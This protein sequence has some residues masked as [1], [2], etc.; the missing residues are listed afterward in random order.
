LFLGVATGRGNAGAIVGVGSNMKEHA[1]FWEG[2]GVVLEAVSGDGEL[3][4]YKP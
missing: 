2:S 3:C 4:F 1:R